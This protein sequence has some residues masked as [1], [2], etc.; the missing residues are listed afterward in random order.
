MSLKTILFLIIA[1][2]W[3][4]GS[5]M[6]QGLGQRG[7]RTVAC[8][9]EQQFNYRQRWA[10]FLEIECPGMSES[11]C[12]LHCGQRFQSI[13]SWAFN[14]CG[15]ALFDQ[16]ASPWECACPSCVGTSVLPACSMINDR[17][18]AEVLRRNSDLFFCKLAYDFTI[19]GDAAVTCSGQNLCGGGGGGSAN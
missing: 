10:K 2:A 7:G 4:S 17:S 15:E 11:E 9:G 19:I 6:A 12:Q 5:A 1:V 14:Q 3:A 13:V 8:P 16:L 18:F